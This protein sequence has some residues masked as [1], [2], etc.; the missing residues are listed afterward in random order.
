[1]MASGARTVDVERALEQA[2]NSAKNGSPEARSGQIGDAARIAK[3]ILEEAQGATSVWAN[4]E[5]INDE[6]IPDKD[7]SK[8]VK[9]LELG[10]LGVIR[11]ALLRDALLAAYR[12]SAPYKP[13]TV[14]LCTFVQLTAAPTIAAKLGSE[15]WALDLG[16]HPRIAKHAMTENARRVSRLHSI[17]VKDWTKSPPKDRKL[18][19][20]R[21]AIK[22]VRDN[23]LAHSLDI[24]GVD[25]PII[26]DIRHMIKLTL[27][28]A[29][30]MAFVFLG[31]AV[32][33]D[34]FQEFCRERAAKFW[35][36][37]FQAPLEVYHTDM[38][39]RREIG[40]GQ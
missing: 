14:T 35:Q 1:M 19:E 20:L 29:T 17:V 31:S 18:L 2:A 38:N 24:E 5:A 34:K 25:H 6:L 39:R 40:P 21:E 11:T 28:L 10:A 12:L 26:D 9:H 7:T 13:N 3:R 27:E 30:D 36:F 16:H 23:F 8:A 37:A 4:W 22:P 15:Q 33:A 32:E